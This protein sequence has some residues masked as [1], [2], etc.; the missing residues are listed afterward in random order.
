MIFMVLL[1]MSTMAYTLALAITQMVI[2]TFAHSAHSLH[3]ED[4]GVSSD[5]LTCPVPHRTIIA[6]GTVTEVE[7]VSIM[8]FN[9]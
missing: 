8:L 6:N 9:L 2:P 7:I 5:E 4:D 1:N 3:Q